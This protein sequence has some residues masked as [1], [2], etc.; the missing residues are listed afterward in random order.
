MNHL[1]SLITHTL[2]ATLLDKG[3]SLGINDGEETVLRYCDDVEVLM[4]GLASTDSDV[5]IVYEPVVQGERQAWRQVGWILLIWGN[6]FD[7]ISDHGEGMSDTLAPVYTWITDQ[8]REAYAR[9]DA[10]LEAVSAVVA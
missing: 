4:K 5:L 1:E 7:L 8:E 3:C 9:L 6:D 10:T 2:I